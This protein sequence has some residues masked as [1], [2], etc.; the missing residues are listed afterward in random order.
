LP[1]L[2]RKHG[3]HVL[4]R[5]AMMMRLLHGR[6]SLAVDFL[7]ATRRLRLTTNP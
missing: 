7:S 4:Q 6:S 2:F 5:L 1:L 3:R